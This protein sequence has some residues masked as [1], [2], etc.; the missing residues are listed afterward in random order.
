MWFWKEVDV[1]FRHIWGMTE[2]N[3]V[4]TVSHFVQTQRDL[5]KTPEQRA[6]NLRTQGLP[7]YIVDWAIADTDNLNKE[8]PHDGVQSG[9]LLVKG[10]GV[11]ASYWRGVGAD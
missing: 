7:F 4:G 10:P 3:P 9:E 8:I 11:T 6:E 1:E 5:L 2:M